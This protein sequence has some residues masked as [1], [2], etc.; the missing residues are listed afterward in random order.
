MHYV[1]IILLIAL[2][3]V[4]LSPDHF[5]RLPPLRFAGE[6]LDM[7][8]EWM[9]PLVG[10]EPSSPCEDAKLTTC[11]SGFAIQAGGEIGS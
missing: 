6:R 1:G 9:L 2:L 3:P 4:H 10:H 5:V 7:V 11:L 8:L